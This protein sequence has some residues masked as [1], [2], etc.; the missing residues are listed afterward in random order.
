M[1]DSSSTRHSSNLF[2]PDAEKAAV[3]KDTEDPVIGSPLWS[4]SGPSKS[5]V[6]DPALSVSSTS[7]I[8]AS[9]KVSFQVDGG[10]NAFIRNS[11]IPIAPWN[12]ALEQE[13]EDVGEVAKLSISEDGKVNHQPFNSSSSSSSAAAAA[14][15]ANTAP[16]PPLAADR[17]PEYQEIL[18]INKEFFHNRQFINRDYI[19]LPIISEFTVFI[20][21]GAIFPPLALVVCYTISMTTYFIQLIIGRVV[22]ISRIQVELSQFIP[23]LNE[24]CRN[25]RRLFLQSIPS[26]S[27]LATFFWGFFLFDILGDEI[28]TKK[29]IWILFVIGCSPILMYFFENVIENYFPFLFED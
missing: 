7:G 20:T 13:E 23:K 9:R 28:G 1:K 19:V 6:A 18:E 21:F 27:I 5:E 14:F 10:F 11:S 22:V 15:P 29:A 24:E 3:Q 25:F 2:L 8:R 26:M 4:E 16:A 12:S 17:S